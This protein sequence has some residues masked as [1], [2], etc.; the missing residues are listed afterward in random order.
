[1]FQAYL[2]SIISKHT[3]YLVYVQQLVR[4]ARSGGWQLLYI[5]S[6]YLVTMSSKHAWHM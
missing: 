2:L 1:M 4:F 6:E 3:Q 5:H